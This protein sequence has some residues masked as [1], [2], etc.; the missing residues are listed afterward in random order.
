MTR[1]YKVRM[2][3]AGAGMLLL[4]AACG[5]NFSG[6]GSSAS[7]PGLAGTPGTAQLVKTGIVPTRVPLHPSPTPTAPAQLTGKVTVQLATIPQQVSDSMVLTINNQTNQQILF[8]DHLTE[9]TVLLLQVQS[10][11]S[12]GT[13]QAVAPCKLM[14]AT[15]LHALEAGK[16]LSITLTPPGSQWIPGLYRALLSYV[17]SGA[18]HTLRTVFSPSFQVGS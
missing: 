7:Q 10:P 6:S 2:V 13:W 12:S 16:T 18:D 11:A 5:Q 4:L 3:I 15:R 1:L 17:P 9:C 14:I 8:S